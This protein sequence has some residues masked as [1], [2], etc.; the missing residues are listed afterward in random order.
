MSKHMLA[1]LLLAIFTCGP[2]LAVDPL[3]EPQ[4]EHLSE[5]MGSL[6]FLSPLC[7]PGGTDWRVQMSEL[8][9]LDDPTDDR[10]QRLTGAFN[11]GYE[12]YSHVYRWCTPSA[13]MAMARLLVDA[14][15]TARSIH[16]H[17]AQ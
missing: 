3:Y 13:R 4:M 11:A 8:I 9:A 2:A 6:Y 1:G 17:Y 10:R 15:K 7:E 5:V 12:A 16:G 14:E